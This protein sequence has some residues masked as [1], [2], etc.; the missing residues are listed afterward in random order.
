MAR[1]ALEIWNYFGQEN[2]IPSELKEVTGTTPTGL[3]ILGQQFQVQTWRDV[4]E[5]TLNTV[6][7]LEP[8]KFDIIAQNFPRYL[9]KDKNKFR[10]IRQLQNGYFIEV[11][12]SAQNIQ[13]FCSQAME[14][15]ELTSE[16]WTVIVN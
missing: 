8:D 4:L 15:I 10:A 14:T 2:S 5:Q 9:G 16:D 13:K 3:N 1:S 12:L 11:N 6:A 7:D